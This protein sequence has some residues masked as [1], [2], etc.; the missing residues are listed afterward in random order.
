V[1]SPGSTG[2]FTDASNF[3][4]SETMSQADGEDFSVSL[5]GV[6]VDPN[7]TTTTTSST[8]TTVATTASTTATTTAGGGST[9]AT[10]GT[11]LGGLRAT[12]D[13]QEVE[14]GQEQ[15]ATATGF[16]PGEQVTAVQQPGEL[17]LGTETADD[18]GEVDFDWTISEDA[19]LGTHEFVA[20][21]TESGAVSARFTVVAAGTAEEDGDDDDD[22][23]VSPLLIALLVLLALAVIGALVWFAYRRGQQSGGPPEDT[24]PD[25]GPPDA[26]PDPGLDETQPHPSV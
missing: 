14:P 19:A 9:T 24:P 22:S 2:T 12:V 21:G 23:D 4:V 8:T 1:F 25:D 17:D 3:T 20:T 7:A 15:E 11:P 5:V 18:D 10:T 16:R 13:R 26:P 6:G